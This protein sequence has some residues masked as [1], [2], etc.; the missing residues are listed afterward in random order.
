M[1]GK[2]KNN[3]KNSIIVNNAG[4]VDLENN[5]KIKSVTSF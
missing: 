2:S 4:F 5:P 1:F 3:M